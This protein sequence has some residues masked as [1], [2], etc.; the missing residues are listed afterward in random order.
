MKFT[1]TGAGG[2]TTGW[3]TVTQLTDA[4]SGSGAYNASVSTTPAGIAQP[5]LNE[6]VF[7]DVLGANRHF[8]ITIDS[9]T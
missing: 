3:T 7:G 4:A 6:I 5:Q 9:N 8:S 1:A 2:L